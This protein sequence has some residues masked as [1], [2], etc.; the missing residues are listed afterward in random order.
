MREFSISGPQVSMY[1]K[2]LIYLV[3][4]MLCVPLYFSLSIYVLLNL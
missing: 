4:F 2:S 3:A 1:T